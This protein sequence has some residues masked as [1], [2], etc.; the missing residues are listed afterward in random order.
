M[1]EWRSNETSRTYTMNARADGVASA[2]A[3]HPCRAAAVLRAVVRGRHPGGD[4]GGGRRVAPDGAQ[5]LRVKEGVALAATEVLSAEH[6]AAQAKPGDAEGAIPSRSASTSDSVTPTSVGCRLQASGQH[7]RSSTTHG[8]TTK[9]GSTGLRRVVA[10]ATD[11]PAC[12]QRTAAATD[13]YTWKLRRD[14]RLSRAE[15]ERTMVDLVWRAASQ[16]SA[17][18]RSDRHSTD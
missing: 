4:R 8:R 2:R 11:A 14:L 1:V 18:A 17:D 5:P 13:A 6:S 9:R 16:S 12:R 3:H 7:R 15:T 10:V